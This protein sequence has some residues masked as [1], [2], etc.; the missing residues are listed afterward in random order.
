MSIYFLT[1]DYM[2]YFDPVYDMWFLTDPQSTLNI[3]NG[4]ELVLL[5]TADRPVTIMGCVEEQ[6]LC[7]PTIAGEARCKRFTP[8]VS[9]NKL[10]SSIN[11]N[12]AQIATARRL[13]IILLTNDLSY[14]T[15]MISQPILASKT[16][17]VGNQY[18]EL[19]KDQWRTEVGRWFSIS[20]I[21]IQSGFVDF[22]TGPSNPTLRQYVLPVNDTEGL[23]DCRRQRVRNVVGVRNCNL[24]AVL[25]VV[26]PGLFIIAVGLTL[27]T[28][29]GCCQRRLRF[30][31]GRRLHWL[32]DGIFQQQR[33]V[34]EAAGVRGWNDKDTNV[35]TT[36]EQHFPLIDANDKSYQ[37]LENS[38]PRATSGE[39]KGVGITVVERLC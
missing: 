19:P 26:I 2:T 6:E 7:N 25:A 28:A 32:L 36:D 30:G 1:T 23:E 37:R 20:M 10:F 5:Y 8:S 15:W 38:L 33:L 17:I 27:D 34:Y 21:M 4:G 13:R 11:L 14:I 9:D 31:D 22:V 18:A 39:P 29:V 3:T 24:T 35:P 12:P 16:V